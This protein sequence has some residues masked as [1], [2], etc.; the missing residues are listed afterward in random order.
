MPR[1]DVSPAAKSIS[2]RLFML[3]FRAL[4]GMLVVLVLLMIV[5]AWGILS[6]SN[7]SPENIEPLLVYMLESHYQARGSWDGVE[8]I[9]SNSSS[10]M[11]NM[12]RRGW[13]D[14]ILL[15]V[16]GRVVLDGGSAQSPLVGH[17]YAISP[18]QI[19]HSIKS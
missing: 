9:F 17:F 14:T 16:Q 3:V 11:V 18:N 19:S 8:N 12:Y 15:D 5:A 1:P 4:A 6:W 10:S 7:S 13:N 2:R